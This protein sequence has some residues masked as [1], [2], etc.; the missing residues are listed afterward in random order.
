[1]ALLLVYNTNLFIFFLC[2]FLFLAPWCCQG[3]CAVSSLCSA[4]CC[5]S[6]IQCF[7]PQS[8]LSVWP[9]WHKQWHISD[10]RV[11]SRITRVGERRVGWGR[12]WGGN[13]VWRRSLRGWQTE[14]EAAYPLSSDRQMSPLPAWPAADQG[15]ARRLLKWRNLRA[16]QGASWSFDVQH[17]SKSVMLNE[18]RGERERERQPLQSVTKTHPDGQSRRKSRPEA[19]VVIPHLCW[20]RKQFQPGCVCATSKTKPFASRPMLTIIYSS[21]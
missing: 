21:F 9:A 12:G 18:L 3:F 17:K 6:C 1:M 2:F 10:R 5:G 16:P 14:S 4:F 8:P 15:R 11:L 20:E 19:A 7:S 13:G